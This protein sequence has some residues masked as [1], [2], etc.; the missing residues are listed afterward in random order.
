VSRA[1]ATILAAAAL[2]GCGG[3][4]AQQQLTRWQSGTDA[5][6]RQVEARVAER[7]RP[8]D[9]RNLD[10]VTVRSVAD[11]RAAM[12]AVAARPLP[13][14]SEDRVRPF[15]DAVRRVEPRLDELVKAG[16]FLDETRLLV[17]VDKVHK[18]ATE[19]ERLA[20]RAGLS[21]CARP[22]FA[23]DVSDALLTP[24][25]VQR[26]NEIQAGLRHELAAWRS[27]RRVAPDHTVTFL[28]LY[29]HLSGMGTTLDDTEDSFAGL[30]PPA[31]VA[32]LLN[33]HNVLVRREAEVLFRAADRVRRQAFV[34]LRRIDRRL[35]AIERRRNLV[36]GKLSKVIGK[37]LPRFAPGTGRSS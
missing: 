25:F 36:I 2:A 37:P 23:D 4:S 6:C 20:R 28:D 21:D 13:K 17:A 19:L 22:G 33:A 15:V 10:R 34:S 29:E 14:G 18:P 9:V 35:A 30:Y 8:V 32:G 7:G 31:D 16:E 1:A 11:I 3:P 27:D 12:R 5:T 26:F 24:L